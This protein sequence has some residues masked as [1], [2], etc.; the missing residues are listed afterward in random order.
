MHEPDGKE[1]L[2]E[3][4]CK[5]QHRGRCLLERLDFVAPIHGAA[6]CD[7]LW[8]DEAQVHD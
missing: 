2:C 3:E 4:E 1:R 7:H 5:Y 8:E 6:C